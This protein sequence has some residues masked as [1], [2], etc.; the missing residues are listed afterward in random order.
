[1]TN[2]GVPVLKVSNYSVEF[3]VD[4]VWY[5]AATNLNFEL[6]PGQTLALVGESGSGKSTVAMGIM[7]LLASNSRTFGSVEVKGSEMV[8]APNIFY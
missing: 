5:P 2:A 4:G 8:G 6:F 7:G 1:M 3:W